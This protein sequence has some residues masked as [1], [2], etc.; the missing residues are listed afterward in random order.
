MVKSVLIAILIVL[1][2]SACQA[3]PPS[4]TGELVKVRLPV[5]YIPNVQ[6]A[7][8]YVAIEKGF[9]AEQGIDL[10]LDYSM[11]IDAVALV[12]A[13][14]LQFAIASG[15]QI[16]LGRSHELPVVYV[17]AW[18]QDYPVGVVSL[19]ESGITKPADLRGKTVG[20]P[21]LSGASY[22]GLRAL[23]ASAGLKESDLTLDVI[24]FTQVESL[25]SRR[26]DA[27][28]V[29]IANEPVQLAGRGYGVNVMK[30]ADYDSLVGNGLIT[31]EIT[32]KEQPALVQKM[33]DAL[34]RGV[35][36]A[37][38]HPD[39]AFQI[40]LKYVENLKADDPIQRHVLDA[41]IGLWKADQ[42][43]FSEQAK[44]EHMQQVLLDMGLIQNQLDLEEVFTN[45]FVAQP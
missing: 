35:R 19:A 41:S 7:P 17:A 25:V 15:E 31:N 8:L 38:E 10:A 33:V 1:L 27:V 18:Y 5:G 3:A 45:Q 26:D 12:G 24:G 37:T 22:I 4:P 42:L 28:V 29:Y 9:F 32:I 16:L 20:L 14:E 30:V 11:E 2:L 39:E 34:M 43:G 21:M 40:C 6:F 44:W 23:L 36:Y 13:N